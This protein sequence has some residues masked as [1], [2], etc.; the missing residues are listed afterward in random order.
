M[1]IE[2]EFESDLSKL[3]DNEMVANLRANCEVS[4]CSLVTYY[5]LRMAFHGYKQIT[6]SHYCDSITSR[7]GIFKSGRRQRSAN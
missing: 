3:V 6:I 2:G 1:L 4:N 5:G 7:C